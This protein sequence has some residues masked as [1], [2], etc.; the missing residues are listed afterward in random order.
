ME[1][2]LIVSYVSLEIPSWQVEMLSHWRHESE[3]VSTISLLLL[4]KGSGR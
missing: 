1:Q 3:A 2:E 4:K